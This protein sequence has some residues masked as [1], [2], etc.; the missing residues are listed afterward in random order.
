MNGLNPGPDTGD[1]RTLAG[2]TLAVAAPAAA[3]LSAWG[4]L[5][6]AIG[7]AIDASHLVLEVAEDVAAATIPQA[8]PFVVTGLA[9]ATTNSIVSNAP[10]VPGSIFSVSGANYGWPLRGGRVVGL[11]AGTSATIQGSW[12][13]RT[14]AGA[15]AADVTGAFLQASPR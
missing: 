6:I 7:R 4:T 12:N 14:V 8:P 10:A 13:P 11:P 5:T 15:S 9:L 2:A 1:L 3:G